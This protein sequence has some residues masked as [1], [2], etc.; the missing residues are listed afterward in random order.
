MGTDLLGGSCVVRAFARAAGSKEDTIESD[1]GGVEW[2]EKS[3][4]GA[5]DVDSWRVN[6]CTTL[7]M[8]GFMTCF[9][10]CDG[11]SG[12]FRSDIMCNEGWCLIA[13]PLYN[14][15]YKILALKMVQPY[16]IEPWHANALP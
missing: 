14:C 6:D 15:I 13:S 4:E 1:G 11:R 3:G 5:A 8:E 7:L 12:S 2:D 10:T 9:D 16:L